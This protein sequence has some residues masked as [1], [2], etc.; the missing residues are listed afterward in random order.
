[1]K[2]GLLLLTIM[3]MVFFACSKDNKIERTYY[4][5]ILPQKYFVERIVG[6]MFNIEVLVKPG[7]S[8]ATYEPTTKQ[9]INLSNAKALFTI[10]VAFED[11]LVPKLTEQYGDLEIVRTD[12]NIKKHQPASF[13][14]LFEEDHRD[15]DYHAHQQS[16]SNHHHEGLDPH[17]WLSPELV[18]I[19]VA[20]ISDYFIKAYPEKAS[21][22]KK[23]RDDF[24]TELDQVAKDIEEVF[25][26]RQNREFLCFHPAWGYFADQFKLKQIPIEIEGKEPTPKEQ[27]QIL[28]FARERKIKVIFVQAQFNQRIASSIAEQIGGSVISIDPLAEDYLVNLKI[29]ANKLAESME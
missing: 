2:K 13:I 7:Q 22:F 15:I 1:M 18:K 25:N 6:D 29:I 24:F 16:D 5:S 21:Y 19:Q 14:Q 12:K 27:Q 10:G 20:N 9:M 17:I 28:A 3:I 26:L 23:N 4:V 11:N 8:P